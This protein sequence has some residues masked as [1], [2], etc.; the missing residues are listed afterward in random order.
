MPL[1]LTGYHSV[2]ISSL[3]MAYFFQNNYF[4]FLSEETEKKEDFAV[5]MVYDNK[6]KKN[7]I[8]VH[9]QLGRTSKKNPCKMRCHTLQRKKHFLRFCFFYII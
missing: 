4:L 2:G 5:G 6:D 7:M 8:I 9:G 1:Y 3:A